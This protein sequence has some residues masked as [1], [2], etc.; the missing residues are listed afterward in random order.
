MIAVPENAADGDGRQVLALVEDGPYAGM[1]RGDK[2]LRAPQ[3]FHI[4]EGD[5]G[6]ILQNLVND[7]TYWSALVL[8]TAYLLVLYHQLLSLCQ[9][10]GASVGEIKFEL[11]YP[12]IGRGLILQAALEELDLPRLLMNDVA[13]RV[14]ALI[15]G[16]DDLDYRLWRRRVF[17][18]LSLS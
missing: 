17:H 12:D 10:A 7:D 8:D 13:K 11:L 6:K 15:V 5:T 18:P 14:Y 16:R 2:R 4:V 3:A 9:D 1:P